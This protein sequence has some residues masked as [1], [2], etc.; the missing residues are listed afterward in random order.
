MA[1]RWLAI[2]QMLVFRRRLF[3][4]RMLFG[5]QD[6]RDIWDGLLLRPWRKGDSRA[7]MMGI[8]GLGWGMDSKNA[9][10]LVVLC[11]RVG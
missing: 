2:N 11:R 1:S 9:G 5:M 7:E 10:D 6:I 4:I 3:G 8:K